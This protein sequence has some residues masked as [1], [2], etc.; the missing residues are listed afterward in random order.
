MYQFIQ[1]PY[2]LQFDGEKT[3]QFTK[4]NKKDVL[5]NCTEL[6]RK[7]LMEQSLKAFIQQYNSALIHNNTVVKP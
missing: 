7:K 1:H 2:I 4:L 3:I 6:D 5:E